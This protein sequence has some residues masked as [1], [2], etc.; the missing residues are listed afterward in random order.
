MPKTKSKPS[1]VVRRINKKS[2]RKQGGFFMRLKT[3]EFFKAYALF[4]PD[5]EEAGN[6]GWMEYLEH[7]DNSNNQ[8]VP[9][10]E[11]DCYMC[12]LGD[13]PSTRALT[14]WY[15]PD[16]AAKEKFKVFKMNG[17]LIRDFVEIHEEEGGVFGRRFRLKRLSDKGE[18]RVSPQSDKPLTK[19]EI[20]ALVKQAQDEAGIDFEDLVLKQAKAAIAKFDAVGALTEVDDDDDDD[21]DEE[22]TPKTKSRR[23]K[24]KAEAPEPD[25]DDDDDEDEEDEDDDDE[26]EDS[27]DTEDEDEDE[28]EDEDEDDDDD[29]EDEDEE[30][31][32][33]TSEISGDKFSVVST[34][35]RDETVTVKMNGKNTKLFVGEGLDVDFDKVKKGAEITIDAVLDDENDWVLTGLKVKKAKT[36]A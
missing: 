8:Y 28:S 10:T 26:S 14:L 32:S 19:K 25:D 16:G 34:S 22:E 6:P 3:D 1:V 4:T 27:E 13:N 7:Y 18:Y 36:K 12:E 9:C 2:E 20:K 35:E 23:G 33:E 5:P 24:E 31:E 15:F 29:D 17:Y 11:D 30:E 21:D